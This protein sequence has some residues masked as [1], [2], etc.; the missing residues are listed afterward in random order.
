MGKMLSQI[1][2][3]APLTVIG[4]LLFMAAFTVIVIR[5]L[6]Q[7]TSQTQEFSRMP[8]AESNTEVN[9]HE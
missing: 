3:E 4:M 1:I 6:C 8:L 7:T 2:T 5:A 9:A